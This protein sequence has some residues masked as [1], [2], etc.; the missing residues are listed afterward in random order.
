MIY[1]KMLTAIAAILSFLFCCAFSSNSLKENVSEGV[2][3][4]IRQKPT[5]GHDAPRSDYNPFSAEL[6]DYVVLLTVDSD[7]G[8]AEVT[9][10]SVEGDCYYTVFDT[11]DG[12]IILPINGNIGDSYT[13]T[14]VT[15]DNLIFEGEFYL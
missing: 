11:A 9:L 7:L 2:R 15:F 13:I 14:I 10:S 4:I 12:S 6:L 5:E 3:I 1:K 8:D